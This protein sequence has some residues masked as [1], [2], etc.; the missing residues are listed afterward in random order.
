[1]K[2]AGL[3][4]ATMIL[5]IV[6]GAA[7]YQNEWVVPELVFVAGTDSAHYRS[8]VCRHRI[9]CREDLT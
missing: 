2:I 8:A 9:S 6:G 3:R 7:T 5:K 1:M 4:N